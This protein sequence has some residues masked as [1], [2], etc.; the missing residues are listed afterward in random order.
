MERYYITTTTDFY[1]KTYRIGKYD[2]EKRTEIGFM[3]DVISIETNKGKLL[4]V[5]RAKDVL[6]PEE[7]NGLRE[8]TAETYGKAEALLEQTTGLAEELLSSINR[9]AIEIQAEKKREIFSVILHELGHAVTAL[10][11]DVKVRYILIEMPK[12]GKV[13]KADEMVAITAIYDT[14]DKKAKAEICFGGVC[15]ESIFLGKEI[16]IE[17]ED[18]EMLLDFCPSVKQWDKIRSRVEKKLEN[19]YKAVGEYA[20]ELTFSGVEEKG[21]KLVIEILEKTLDDFMKKQSSRFFVKE[22]AEGTYTIGELTGEPNEDGEQDYRGY[23]SC[24]DTLSRLEEKEDFLGEDELQEL[25]NN[26]Y[27]CTPLLVTKE[28]YLK[29]ESI[30]KELLSIYRENGIEVENDIT[31]EALQELPETTPDREQIIS[32]AESLLYE[33]YKTISRK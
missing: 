4:K 16:E 30:Y 22:F 17:G 25:Q 33:A 9:K 26:K 23:Y 8:A 13:S 14:D 2:P 1:G 21:G 29:V 32:K 19:Y 28:K 27:P 24:R 7:T 20:R 3:A 12:E 15:V 10:L 5:E 11:N 6:S 18:R 31:A